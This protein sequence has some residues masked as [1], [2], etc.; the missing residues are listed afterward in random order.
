[1]PTRIIRGRLTGW[2]LLSIS[3]AAALPFLVMLPLAYY[4]SERQ[5]QA[6]ANAANEIVLR[7]AESIL[8]QAA[9]LSATLTTLA[10]QPCDQVKDQLQ[11][12]GTFRP[13]FRAL[14]L[15]REHGLYCSSATGEFRQPVSELTGHPGPLP[16][17]QALYL[18]PGTPM[19]PDRPAL[20][21]TLGLEDGRGV[22]AALDGQYLL[23][24]LAAAGP[25]DR[26]S[27]AIALKGS[28]NILAGP[29]GSPQDT[30]GLDRLPAL[31]SERYPIS[32]LTG[33]RP[34][35][36]VALR[37]ALLVRYAPFV[38]LA[39]LLLAYA[40]YRL[41]RQRLSMVA[42]IR[43]A[44]RNDEFHVHYQPVLELATGRC[45]GVEALIRWDKP[46]T[47]PI[48]P[49]LLFA[50]AQDNA[51]ALPLTRHLFGLI[52]RD[53][54]TLAIPPGFHI[55][56]NITAEHLASTDM[57]ADVQR[58]QQGL[59]DK[60]PRLV[61][62]ITE[63]K[64]VPDTDVVLK[65]MQA[66]RAAGVQFAID[67]F[68]TGHSSLAY[69]ERFTVDYI[70]I[71]RGFVSV[72]DTDAVN[73]PVLELI[74]SLGARLAVTLIAEGI[75]TQTQA[76]YLRGKGVKYAQGFLFAKPMAA[77]ALGTWLASQPLQEAAGS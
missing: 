54:E 73:A 38:L 29:G 17:G 5:A 75:E 8:N 76:A 52:Q 46:G 57:I 15:V 58:L 66:L 48:R 6:Q 53:V 4:E 30:P 10:G 60:A 45:S 77:A 36:I 23:D 19:V 28:D 18:L 47:G 40:A 25:R 55:G 2:R 74:I 62:E 32:V 49:D 16:V 14:V 9:N 43:R 26:F 34:A 37:D 31:T 22:I 64:V 59:R 13:Y 67:D 33:V 71:D 44:M 20:L 39:S 7:Q 72:I 3:L 42:E 70:K 56:V 50:V 68:G 12:I 63:R 24:I 61:L 69:L 65:N 41:H 21:V 51:L 11:R 1:M 27:M 35:V